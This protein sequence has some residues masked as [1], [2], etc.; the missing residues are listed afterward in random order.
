V[1]GR[2]IL[3]PLGVLLLVGGLGLMGDWYAQNREMDRLLRS[4]ETAED[5]INRFL[6]ETQGIFADYTGRG[7]IPDE[8]RATLF[9]RLS[10]AARASSEAVAARVERVDGLRFLPWHRDLARA[11]D[12][13]VSH[14]AVWQAYLRSV[15]DDSEA[16][17]NER[18]PEI[19]RTYRAALADLRRAIPSRPR[20]DFG[21]RVDELEP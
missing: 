16:N 17:Y 6:P 8:E 19:L 20:Q 4:I 18:S 5:T 21:A 14:A 1:R 15:I 13:Y 2:G 11:R 9:V 10:Q 12:H 7:P 3:L